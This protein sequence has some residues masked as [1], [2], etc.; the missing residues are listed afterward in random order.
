VRSPSSCH[1]SI[2]A[3]TAALL[4][5]LFSACS[6]P[7]DVTTRTV[8]TYVPKACA[9]PSTGYATYA[10]L[11]D[12]PATAPVTG[13]LL[14]ATG[15]VLS[16]ID[17]QARELIV[18]ATQGATTWQGLGPVPSSGDVNV[19][20]LPTLTS[21]AFSPSVEMRAG[22]SFVPIGSEQ[23]LVVGGSPN[24]QPPTYVVHLDTGAV[25]GATP[26]L[27]T[28]RTLASV[29]PFGQGA[30]VAGGVGSDMTVLNSAEIYSVTAGGFG[31]SPLI[32]AEPRSEQGAAVLAD[33]RTLLVGGVSTDDVTAL[34]SIVIVDPA[35]LTVTAAGAQLQVARKDPTVLRLA[36]GEI[37]VAGGLDSSGAPVGTLEWFTPDASAPST[38]KPFLLVPGSARSYVAL[39][40]GGALAVIAPP[41][42]APADFQNV[43]LIDSAGVVSPATSIEGSLTRPILF[44]GAG[45]APVLWTGDRW[46]VWQPWLG[47]FGALGVVDITP[48]NIG[49]SATCSPDPGLAMWLDA[50]TFNPVGLRFDTRNPYST[51]ASPFLAAG[52]DNPNLTPTDLAPD[53]LP[54]T[55]SVDYDAGS[56]TLRLAAGASVFVT[57]R[58]Y[59]D[60]SITVTSAANQLPV[61]VLRDDAGDELDVGA[62]A[63]TA[64][65][66]ACPLPVALASSDSLQVQRQGAAVTFS[67]ASGT[68]GT[69]PAASFLATARLSIGVRGAQ[70][71]LPS[72]VRGLEVTR[73]G[74]P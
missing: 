14:S 68:T 64:G 73:L 74:A 42:S 30:L 50:T 2:R 39:Q 63:C 52:S 34:H 55:G 20:V 40:Q 26:G 57:D 37:L 36:D 8:T 47:S 49:D 17:T 65:C 25:Q 45:G 56:S 44:G 12:Y 61:L 66:T 23:A 15:T 41:S 3:P 6:K 54:G 9:V 32:L 4:L 46:L 27:Q 38:I 67:G 28:A 58:T 1:R 43:W 51:L 16:E 53:G 10:A 29:T 60:V 70:A 48:A 31:S 62:A 21:C 7:T 5:G 35:G 72:M 69:C 18:S 24:A 19:L 59:A 22:S 71:S 33:G 11:G 13:H